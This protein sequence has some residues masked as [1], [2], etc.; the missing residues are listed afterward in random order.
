[1]KSP[2]PDPKTLVTYAEARAKVRV[3]DLL[4]RA[5][6]QPTDDDD[7][8]PKIGGLTEQKPASHT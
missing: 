8:R 6:R 2:F 4:Y 1:M 7:D 3:Y 5:T